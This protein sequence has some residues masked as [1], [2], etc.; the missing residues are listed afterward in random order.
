[1]ERRCVGAAL[2]VPD[3]A[4]LFWCLV[5]GSVPWVIVDTFTSNMFRY[6]PSDIFS[7]ISF[8]LQL[9]PP[10]TIRGGIQK[11]PKHL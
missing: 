4:L 8:L 11:V 2:G 9:L 7:S 1:M 10:P 5:P 3:L 6:V